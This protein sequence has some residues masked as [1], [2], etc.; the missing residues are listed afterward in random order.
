VSLFDSERL[1]R[2]KS[3]LKSEAARLR[4]E[5]AVLEAEQRELIARAAAEVFREFDLNNDGS[6]SLEELRLGLMKE[7]QDQVSLQQVERLMQA[8]DVSGDGK[9]QIDEFKTIEEFRRKLDAIVL[10]DRKRVEEAEIAA[11]KEKQLALQKQA[12]LEIVNDGPPT[13][14]D[15]WVSILPYLVPLFDSFQYGQK[16]IQSR[17]DTLA[18]T[19]AIFYNLYESIPFSGLIAFFILS[20]IANNSQ[21]NRLIRFNIQQA[22][23]IDIALIVPSLLSGILTVGLPYAGVALSPEM[24][25]LAS[26][27]T[28]LLF[29]C[30]IIY[31]LV[32]SLVFGVAPNKIPLIS[33]KAEERVNALSRLV[34]PNPPDDKRR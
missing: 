18:S 32:S 2:E 26:T 12:I 34:D 22:I 23:Y 21:L 30:S 14:S 16:F 15:R 13:T 19:L 25:D 1:S 29:A 6:I 33:G 5:A 10:E 31:S 9:L 20:F 3:W 8:F 24:N 28:F 7:M 17:D 11:I 27:A 4:A